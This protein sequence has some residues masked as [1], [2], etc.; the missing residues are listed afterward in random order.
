MPRPRLRPEQRYMDIIPMWRLAE[1]N[2]SAIYEAGSRRSAIHKMHRLNTYRKEL[3][4][5][6]EVTPL[7]DFIVRVVGTEVH[8]IRR[9]KLDLSKLTTGDGVPYEEVFQEIPA[10]GKMSREQYDA[11]WASIKRQ[12][13]DKVIIP[14]VFGEEPPHQAA[15]TEERPSFKPASPPQADR[16][17]FKFEMKPDITTITDVDLVPQPLKDTDR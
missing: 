12:N 15:Q 4:Y 8:I 17:S 7:D 3:R 6:D 14:P 1:A 13:P 5:V 9:P 10:S 11:L 2:G 16:P